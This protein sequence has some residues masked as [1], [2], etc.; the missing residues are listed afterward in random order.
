MLLLKD[1]LTYY[2]AFALI[3]I[4]TNKPLCIQT[5]QFQNRPKCCW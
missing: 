1:K 4:V 5:L 2:P 3:G